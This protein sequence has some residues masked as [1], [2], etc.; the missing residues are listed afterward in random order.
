MHALLQQVDMLFTRKL[1]MS[2]NSLKLYFFLVT[3]AGQRNTNGKASKQWLTLVPCVSSWQELRWSDFSP[4][5]LE[6]A[7]MGDSFCCLPMCADF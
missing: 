5:Q 2:V 7:N 1:F 4:G 3:P 6:L